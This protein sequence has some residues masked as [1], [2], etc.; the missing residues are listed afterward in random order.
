MCSIDVHLQDP[1]GNDTGFVFKGCS[2]APTCDLFLPESCE[3]AGE[4]CYLAG[5]GQ[6][7]CAQTGD[8]MDGEACFYSNDCVT[9]QACIGPNN[10]AFC[11]YLCEDG[12]EAQPPGMGG[13]PNGQTCNLNLTSGFDGLGFCEP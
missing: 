1:E 6:T 4:S 13:C 5:K 9:G 10:D 3:T 2:F 8:L 7:G 11:H 12:S